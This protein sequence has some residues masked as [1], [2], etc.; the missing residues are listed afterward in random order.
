MEID[1]LGKALQFNIFDFLEAKTILQGNTPPMLAKYMVKGGHCN[2]VEQEGELGSPQE[3]T[4]SQ[5][6]E[7][8][9]KWD[10][11]KHQERSSTSAGKKRS[12]SSAGHPNDEDDQNDPD[13]HGDVSGKRSKKRVKE[14]GLKFAC[15]FFKCHSTFKTEDELSNHQRQTVP[16]EICAPESQDRHGLSTINAETEKRLR[17]RKTTK[18]LTEEEKWFN[19]YQII[20]PSHSPPT[21]PYHSDTEDLAKLFKR[22]IGPRFRHDLRERI[23]KAIADSIPISTLVDNIAHQAMAAL[24]NALLNDRDIDEKD[25]ETSQD[26]LP[27]ETFVD[28]LSAGTSVAN[29]SEDVSSNPKNLPNEL[30]SLPQSMNEGKMNHSITADSCRTDRLLATIRPPND[31]N[32]GIEGLN[33][34]L[35]SGDDIGLLKTSGPPSHLESEG[36]VKEGT[37]GLRRT[38]SRESLLPP[39]LG[40]SQLVVHE[41]PSRCSDG[42]SIRHD[43]GDTSQKQPESSQ[44]PPCAYDDLGFETWERAFDQG[45]MSTY[46]IYTTFSPFPE[47]LID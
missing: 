33:S 3:G 29:C 15:P 2:R 14:S 12:T 7:T 6:D 24:A 23:E 35:G 40:A 36:Q 16:C 28:E 34:P 26:W 47:R 21:S 11:T 10:A 42:N 32:S 30:E 37:A 44:L 19:M 20:F 46:D 43:A 41:T 31:S 39:S 8:V 18:S 1:I 45:L 17:S 38:T 9:Q 4:C 27:V 22:S 5:E 25:S 13:K